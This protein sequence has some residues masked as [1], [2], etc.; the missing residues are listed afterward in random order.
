MGAGLLAKAVCHPKNLHLT[1]RFREQ[2]RFRPD[3]VRI[4]FPGRCVKLAPIAVWSFL[5]AKS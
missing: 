3:P 2:A 4:Q 1:H 5:C